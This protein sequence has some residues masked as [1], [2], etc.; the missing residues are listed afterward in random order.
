MAPGT[1][2][3]PAALIAFLLTALAPLAAGAVD[4]ESLVM[5]GP[6]ISGHAETEKECRKCHVPFARDDQR[7]LCLDCHD[8]VDADISRK[9][10][11]HW[12]SEAARTGQ[13]RNCHTDHEGRAADVVRLTPQ[14]FDYSLAASRAGI[15]SRRKCT[16][17]SRPSS[18]WSPT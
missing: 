3:G 4:W 17:A 15:R 8:K 9:S 11:F 1:K 2:R 6:V 12:R 18:E 14:T 13:C 16:V 7:K 10:G 5:P